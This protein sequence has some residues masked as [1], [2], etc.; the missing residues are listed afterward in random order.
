MI[1]P[2]SISRFNNEIQISEQ[3]TY[4]LYGSASHNG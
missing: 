2:F 3:L 4:G 1:D